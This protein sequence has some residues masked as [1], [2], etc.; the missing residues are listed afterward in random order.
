MQ[1]APSQPCVASLRTD[2]DQI[3]NAAARAVRLN[4]QLSAFSMRARA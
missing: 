4:R 2:V 1:Q 3:Q